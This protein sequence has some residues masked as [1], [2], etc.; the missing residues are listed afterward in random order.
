M[1]F[2][3]KTVCFPGTGVAFVHAVI[4]PLS[5]PGWCNYFPRVMIRL[6]NEIAGIGA[7]PKKE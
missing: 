3:H 5:F 1:D 4:V 7:V 6:E 2:I